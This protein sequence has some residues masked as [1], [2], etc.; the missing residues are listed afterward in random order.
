MPPSVSSSSLFSASSCV[1]QICNSSQSHAFSTTPRTTQRT[2]RARRQMFQW[3]NNQGQVFYEPLNNSTNYL[4][5]YNQ[6]GEL[7]R[8]VESRDLKDEEK[9]K[10]RQRAAREGREYVEPKGQAEVLPKETN[11]D[12]MPFPSNNKFVSQ[13]VLSDELREEVWERVM[14]LGRSVRQVSAELGI[15]MARVGAVVR[16]KEIEK[17]WERIVSLVIF[18]PFFN[19]EYCDDLISI[20]LEDYNMVITFNYFLKIHLHFH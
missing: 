7:R 12:L 2:T 15:D 16:L 19:R 4:G 11:R 14:R 17:E 8:V 9:K 13:A 5:A 1:K 18:K 6:S 10:A 3:L 20:S